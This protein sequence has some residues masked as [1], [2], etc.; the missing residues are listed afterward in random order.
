MLKKILKWILKIIAGAVIL[1][2]LWVV[3]LKFIPPPF[4]MAMFFR[5]VEYALD[6][7][8]IRME[9]DWADYDEISHNF[10]RAVIASEDARFLQHS[11]ID[12]KAVDRA[13]KYNERNK[14]RKKQ[15]ASTI[16][17]QTAKNVF[18]CHDRTYL[19]KALELYFTVLIEAVWGKKRILEMYANVV[20]FGKGLYGVEAASQKFYGKPASKLT[21]HQAAMLAAMLPSPRRWNPLKP[22]KY[23]KK[24]QGW[25]LARMNSISLKKLEE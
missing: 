12:W 19:R 3:F 11:G 8:F 5:T 13:K 1:S 16:S 21:Q 9:K 15:G 24:R 25:A 22:T 23:L 14:G 18:L 20:E 17:M 7:E 2:V 4:G 6:G 10:F